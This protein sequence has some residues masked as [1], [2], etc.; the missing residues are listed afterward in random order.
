[1]IQA[2][3][4]DIEGT[5]TSLAFVKD[6]LFPYAK[7]HLPDYLR[8]LADQPAV[9]KQLN[10]VRNTV[11]QVDLDLEGVIA[12]LLEWIATD[13]KATPLKTLQGMLWERGYHKQH[14]QG[15]IHADAEMYLRHWHA[16]G[17]RLYVYSSG[18]IQAQKLLFAHTIYGDLT[19]LFSDYFDTTIGPKRATASYQN[20]AD[21]IQLA[22][23]DIVFLSDIEAELDAAK[24][25][26]MHTRWL[27]R[28][29]EGELSEQPTT[30][31]QYRDF[32]AVD[33]SL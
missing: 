13:N 14:Y 9:Q 6:V 3:V 2:I 24:A 19:S 31:P 32:A 12:V 21:S 8:Q 33:A 28:E 10:A 20:I 15:H 7:Q 5:T 29:G 17:K 11:G 30:H 4:T 18:S 1:M 22:P 23:P 27:V 16:A 26:G 25:A